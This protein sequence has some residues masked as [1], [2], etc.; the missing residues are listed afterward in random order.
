MLWFR[1]NVIILSKVHGLGQL[2]LSSCYFS[3][4]PVPM[5]GEDRVHCLSLFKIDCIWRIVTRWKI[6]FAAIPVASG[7]VFYIIRTVETI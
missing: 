2:W 1:E 7:G 6:S 5:N 4:E 3:A